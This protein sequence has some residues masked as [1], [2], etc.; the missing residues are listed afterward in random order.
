[1]ARLR[2]SIKVYEPDED[3]THYAAPSGLDQVTLCGVPDWLGG[4]TPGEET[5]RIVNCFACQ[6]IVNM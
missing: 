2:T 4:R 1:M 5:N 3:V 6:Q